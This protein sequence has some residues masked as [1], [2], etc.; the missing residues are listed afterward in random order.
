MSSILIAYATSH[1]QTRAIAHT[2]GA[3]LR[4]RG[5]R[6][7]VIDVSERG[8]PGPAGYDAVILGSRIH[9]GAFARSI[10][11]FVRRHRPVL[12]R[13]MVALFSVSMSAA[14]PGGDAARTIDA[15]CRRY[16]LA[17][18]RTAPFAGALR[19]VAYGPLLRAFMKYMSGRGGH[20][21]DTSRDH[22]Y[23][24]WAAV[25]RFADDI[26][27][28]LGRSDDEAAGTQGAGRPVA[29]L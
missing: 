18:R 14:S 19:F 24:D 26:D 22:E 16:R 25:D 10:R 1:G 20:A 4:E 23:T 17:P 8:G 12:R 9:A 3:R 28:D 5:H 2:V 7:D 11:R 29:S 15:F 13:Q 27:L 6:V 21:V